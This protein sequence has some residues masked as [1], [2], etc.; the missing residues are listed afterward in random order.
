MDTI[1]VFSI[2]GVGTEIKNTSNK[3]QVCLNI[4]QKL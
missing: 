3:I 4:Y 1:W 2:L